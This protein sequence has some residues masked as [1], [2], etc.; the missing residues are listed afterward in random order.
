PYQTRPAATTTT[1]ATT[2]PTPTPTPAFPHGASDCNPPR[3]E[4][5]L[6]AGHN[7]GR[8]LMRV[9]SR[10]DGSIC[11]AILFLHRPSLSSNR[12]AAAAT[13]PVSAHNP[14]RGPAQSSHSGY[15]ARRSISTV[16]STPRPASSV[17][18]LPALR[19]AHARFGSS[20]RP[21]LPAA[22]V[23]HTAAALEP[24]LD[25]DIDDNGDPPDSINQSRSSKPNR[26]RN[27]SKKELLALIDPYDD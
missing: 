1:T 11:G 26:G 16:T 13:F 25:F 10:I 4:A 15:K 3:R 7:V 22:R 23:N 12:S 9:S 5:G 18:S 24:P 20:P 27:L 17:L 8:Q 6:T 19:V 14:G 2:T 21:S